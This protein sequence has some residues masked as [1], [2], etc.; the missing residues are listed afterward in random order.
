MAAQQSIGELEVSAGL[1]ASSYIVFN[2]TAEVN[3]KVAFGFEIR[4]SVIYL[5]AMIVME[6]PEDCCSF[7]FPTLCWLQAQQTAS[8]HTLPS[9][10]STSNTDVHK[11]F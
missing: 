5:F 4:I 3:L 8:R 2:K 1:S 7:P 11:S 6:D 10:A 9:A